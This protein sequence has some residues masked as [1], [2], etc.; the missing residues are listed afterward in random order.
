[1]ENLKQHPE[2]LNQKKTISDLYSYLDD[3]ISVSQGKLKIEKKADNDRQAWARIIVSAT[4]AYG[5]LIEISE[6]DEMKKRLETLEHS[7]GVNTK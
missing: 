3:V 2:N 7:T 1:M 4:Q 5:K 6:I